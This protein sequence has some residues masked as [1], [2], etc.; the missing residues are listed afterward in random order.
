MAYSRALILFISNHSW[1]CNENKEGSLFVSIACET[2]HLCVYILRVS[3]SPSVCV[4]QIRS[5]GNRWRKMSIFF[6]SLCSLSYSFE[7]HVECEGLG[8]A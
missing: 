3:Y 1:S 5:G 7:L 8:M 2:E 6:E 4:L